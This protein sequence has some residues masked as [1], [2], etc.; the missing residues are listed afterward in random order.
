M[1]SPRS[2]LAKAC[3]EMLYSGDLEP[4][5]MLIGKALRSPHPHCLVNHIDVRPA[6]ALPGV[7][8][9]LTARDIPGLNSIGKT[10]AD[11]EFLSS[12]R[13]RTVL[14]ALAIVAAESDEAADAALRAIQLDLTPLA[15]VFDPEA[16]LA[17]GAPALYP[18]GNLVADFEIVHG[19]VPA[20]MRS[21]D[22]VVDNTYRFPWIEHAFLETEAVLATPGEDG[23]LTVWL[24]CHN[25]YGEREVLSRALA[26]PVEQIRVVLIP[27]GGS[28]GGKDDNIIAVWAALLADCT[29]RPVRF[30]W[31]RQESIRGHSKRHSQII[32]HRLGAQANGELVAA[33]VSILSDTGAYAHW[34]PSIMRFAS[35]QATGPY[36][37][38]HAHVQARL[39]YTN[40][41]VAG[42]MRGWGTPGVEFAAESQMDELARRLGM[43]PLQLRWLN[44]L[45]DGDRTITGTRLPD[46]CRYRETLAAAAR[47]AGQGNA[48]Q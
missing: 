5:G 22:V 35:L 15:A 16:A 38:P 25:I 34:G 1:A 20:A 24:G 43:H 21:A 36:R 45:R 10:I 42:A 17:P 26:R 14:D 19:D 28:F 37:V 6:L 23:R 13:A 11:Q 47:S 3:G 40:N 32:H 7:H 27:A 31:N 44:A 30:V 46:G 18:N 12:E 41:L 48:F 4:P 8:A 39:V 29:Q 9:V 2:H 33:D